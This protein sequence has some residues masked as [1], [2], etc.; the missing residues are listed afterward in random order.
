MAY[1]FLFSLS[2]YFILGIIFS[3]FFLLKGVHSID[4]LVKSSGIVF[5]LFLI[6]ASILLWPYLLYITTKRK[7]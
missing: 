7:I 6:P 4:S 5:R 3:I 2:L 1:I